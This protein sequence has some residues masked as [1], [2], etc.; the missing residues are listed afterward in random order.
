MFMFYSNVL[1][2]FIILLVAKL[3]IIKIWQRIQHTGHIVITSALPFNLKSPRKVP[4]VQHSCHIEHV[5]D[6]NKY[7]LARQTRQEIGNDGHT[8]LGDDTT[9]QELFQEYFKFLSTKAKLESVP[10]LKFF[11]S[12]KAGKFRENEIE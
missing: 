3:W 7:K 10:H 6:A 12:T 4:A 8:W 2:R 5:F 9:L 11:E 1:L